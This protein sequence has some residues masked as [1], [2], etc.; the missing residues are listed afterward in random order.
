MNYKLLIGVGT[1]AQFPWKNISYPP[2]ASRRVRQAYW[3]A[4]SYTD[5]QIGK[6]LTALESAGFA[7][8]TVIA[9]W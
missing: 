9:L 7:D 2:E 6:V 1:D 4:I 3:A 8:E 5:A